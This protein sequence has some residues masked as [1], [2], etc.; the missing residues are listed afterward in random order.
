M[1]VYNVIHRYDNDGGYGDA[2]CETDVLFMFERKEDAEAFVEKYSFPHIWSA[3][4]DK[5]R[6][7]ELSIVE[8]ETVSAGEMPEFD[9]RWLSPWGAENDIYWESLEATDDD[10]V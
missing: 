4:Y 6:C 3:P 2:V 10:C 1:K 5:L 8:A 9:L 7:G